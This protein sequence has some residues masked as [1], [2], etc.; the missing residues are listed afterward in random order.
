[1]PDGF[2]GRGVSLAQVPYIHCPECRLTVY[3]GTAYQDR[4]RCPRCGTEMS[5][6]PRPLF[7]ASLLDARK[8]AAQAGGPDRAAGGPA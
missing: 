7:R 4:K 6:S 2:L 5:Q 3:G 8:R 1:L